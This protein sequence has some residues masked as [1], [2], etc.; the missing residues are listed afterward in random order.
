MLIE[1]LLSPWWK[2]LV[3]M[4]GLI[5]TIVAIKLV[6]KLDVNKWMEYRREAKLLKTELKSAEECGHVWTLYPSSMYSQC[7]LCFVF[8]LTSTLKAA[9]DFDIKPYIIAQVTGMAIKPTK[10]AITTSD[11]IGKRRNVRSP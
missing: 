4:V 2:V 3:Y 7:N 1:E 8:I 11:Y 6:V 9:M 5:G 10:G